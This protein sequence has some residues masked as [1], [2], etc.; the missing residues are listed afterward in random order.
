MSL[1]FHLYKVHY[2]PKLSRT[3]KTCE[4]IQKAVIHKAFCWWVGDLGV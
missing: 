2:S 3:H 1:N 4:P